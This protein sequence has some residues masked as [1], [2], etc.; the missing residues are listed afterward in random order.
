MLHAMALV[1][2]FLDKIGGSL[3]SSLVTDGIN[4]TATDTS[5]RMVC[6]LYE[7]FNY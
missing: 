2:F 5:T 7:R 6:C 3:F 4:N 1:T